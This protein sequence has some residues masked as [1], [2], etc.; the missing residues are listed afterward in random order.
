M[1]L[2]REQKRLLLHFQWKLGE[3]ASGA[4]RKI[5][6]AYGEKAIGRST[7]KE[8]FAKFN[9]G[10]ED[11]EDQPRSGRPVSIENAATDVFA[12]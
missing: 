12:L 7:A 1:E 6:E 3:T 11:L 8:W 9:A 10:T 4:A 5:C 2:T